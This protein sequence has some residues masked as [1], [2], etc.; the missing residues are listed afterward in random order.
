MGVSI[1]DMLTAKAYQDQRIEIRQFLP[2]IPCELKL[3]TLAGQALS[4]P[5]Q[6]FIKS[7]KEALSQQ[8]GEFATVST[9]DKC[10]SLITA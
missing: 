5:A 10:N 1:L 3:V 6:G 4:A 2:D 7:A 9:A 8:P